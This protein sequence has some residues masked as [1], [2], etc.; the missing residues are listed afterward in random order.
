MSI[1]DV[2]RKTE[3]Q[4]DEALKALDVLAAKL[5]SNYTD[6]PETIS[7]DKC[8]ADISKPH[9]DEETCIACWK[10]YALDMARKEMEK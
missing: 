2:L 4:R 7:L 6:C 9:E 3:Q 10:S 8:T 5:G 1:V